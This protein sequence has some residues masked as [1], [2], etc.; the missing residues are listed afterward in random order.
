MRIGGGKDFQ[1]LRKVLHVALRLF[2]QLLALVEQ[3][4][5]RGEPQSRSGS[6]VAVASPSAM[7]CS[8]SPLNCGP[9]TGSGNSRTLGQ[10]AITRHEPSS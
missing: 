3:G 10:P 2:E 7:A 4:S 6:V 1:G 8:A 9:A 5:V